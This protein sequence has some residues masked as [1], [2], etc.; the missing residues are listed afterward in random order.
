MLHPL[1]YPI[2]I[3]LIEDNPSDIRLTQEALKE[4]KLQNNLHV[5]EDG[6]EALDYLTNA[7]AMRKPHNRT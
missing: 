5:V 1:G 7:A 3:L 6:E 4:N 2:E